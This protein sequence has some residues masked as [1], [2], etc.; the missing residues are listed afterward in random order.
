MRSPSNRTLPLHDTSPFLNYSVHHPSPY[1]NLQTRRKSHLPPLSRPS[2]S[3]YVNLQ[4]NNP[5][6]VDHTYVNITGLLTPPPSPHSPPPSSI[7]SPPLTPPGHPV[8]VAMSTLQDPVLCDPTYLTLNHID[9]TMVTSRLQ[10]IPD[11]LL[12][13]PDYEDNLIGAEE[14]D[15]VPHSEPTFYT[16]PHRVSC[17]TPLIR[18]T[19]RLFRSF[20]KRN[21]RSEMLSGVLVQTYIKDNF[22]FTR[23]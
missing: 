14:D 19:R 9:N 21:K 5:D 17:F 23:L 13:P 20:R 6:L 16:V 1:E 3:N 11:H 12:P 15:T 18:L 4:L 8:P 2:D 10:I 22:V 7:S